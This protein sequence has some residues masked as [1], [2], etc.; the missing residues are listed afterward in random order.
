VFSSW[1]VTDTSFTLGEGTVVVGDDAGSATTFSEPPLVGLKINNIPLLM[2]GSSVIGSPPVGSDAVMI[3]L[4]DSEASLPIP[5]PF[6]FVLI[7]LTEPFVFCASGKSS[8]PVVLPQPLLFDH[9][10]VWLSNSMGEF[11]QI[12]LDYQIYQLFPIN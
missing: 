8:L 3:I 1:A 2:I 4:L 12:W 11:D 5:F 9:F 10:L 6:M 7:V